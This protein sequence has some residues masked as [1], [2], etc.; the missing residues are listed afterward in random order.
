[1]TTT[2]Q[3][4]WSKLAIR[5]RNSM[6]QVYRQIRGLGSPRREARITVHTGIIMHLHLTRKG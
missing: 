4:Q 2:L 5:E 6:R 1:M 3:E